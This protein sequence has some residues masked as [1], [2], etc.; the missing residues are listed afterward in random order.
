MFHKFV[1]HQMDRTSDGN[2]V[3]SENAQQQQQQPRDDE[4]PI[5]RPKKR[6][7]LSPERMRERMHSLFGKDEEDGDASCYRNEI[8]ETTETTSAR[9]EPIDYLNLSQKV[10][11]FEDGESDLVYYVKAINAMVKSERGLPPKA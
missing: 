9:P 1:K 4:T 2:V 7:K 5:K 6:V 11:V 10:T 8:V 3:R